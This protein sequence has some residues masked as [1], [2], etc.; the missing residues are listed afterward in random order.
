M[1]RMA[2]LHEKFASEV[3]K[4]AAEE[5]AKV[6]KH[7][8]VDRMNSCRDSFMMILMQCTQM[9]KTHTTFAE[10]I[11]SAVL[12][13]LAKFYQVGGELA[14]T[15]QQ[16]KEDNARSLE[17]CFVELRKSEVQTQHM[18]DLL[19]RQASKVRKTIQ[20]PSARR[21]LFG[22]RIKKEDVEKL[23]VKTIAATQQ[24]AI[25]CQR[26]SEHQQRYLQNEMPTV[27]EEMQVIEEMRIESFRQQMVRYSEIV[28]QFADNYLRVAEDI[29]FFGNAIKNKE[30]IKNFAVNCKFEGDDHLS[31]PQVRYAL[32]KN[33]EEL[34][35]DIITEGE[36]VFNRTYQ[37]IMNLQKTTRPALE[38]PFLIVDLSEAV[39]DLGGFQTEGIFRVPAA[40][41]EVQ[42]L[43]ALMEKKDFKIPSDMSPHVPASLLKEYLRTKRDSLIPTEF[44]DKCVEMGKSLDKVPGVE[45]AQVLDKIPK[46]NRMIIVHLVELVSII[47]A[48][49]NVVKNRMTLANLSMVFAPSILRNPSTDPLKMIENIKNEVSFVQKL[50]QYV[51]HK[52]LP[53]KNRQ[54]LI[55]LLQ[56]GPMPTPE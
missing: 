21:G 52:A 1:S 41:H 55:N 9:A 4:A 39:E 23:Q 25:L 29:N 13:P 38:I 28:E 12:T 36:G 8:P 47:S 3:K 10:R 33:A 56:S 7:K 11:H 24:H 42:Q 46:I 49:R 44:Y 22:S 31:L 15:T 6:L 40:S 53:K 2:T 32:S 54:S 26:A 19:L 18:I 17:R 51:V 48:P 34:K 20:N 27:L 16:S 45:F 14:E 37:S 35:G 43:K 30:D 5:K 50:F